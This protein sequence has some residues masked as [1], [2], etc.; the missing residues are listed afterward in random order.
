MYKITIK[1]INQTKSLVKLLLA[2]NDATSEHIFTSLCENTYTHYS[3]V[4]IH[5]IYTHY[6]DYT[7]KILFTIQKQ[8]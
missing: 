1:I 6:F 5:Q 7:F 8:L 2:D 3:H 4:Y